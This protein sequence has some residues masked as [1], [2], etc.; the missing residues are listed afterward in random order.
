M[1]KTLPHYWTTQELAER[2]RVNEST[3]RRWCQSGKL[4]AYQLR[5][6]W[7]IPDDVAEAFIASRLARW[8]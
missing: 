4:Q 2:L 1:E 3:V 8:H 6:V 5:G 7:L